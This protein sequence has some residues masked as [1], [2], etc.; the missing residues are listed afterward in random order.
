MMEQYTAIMPSCCSIVCQQLAGWLA[1]WLAELT[2]LHLV[3]LLR[4]HNNRHV[5]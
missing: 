2:V 1:G 4:L 5:P 3:L